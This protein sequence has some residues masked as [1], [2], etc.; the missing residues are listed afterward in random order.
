[1]A[2]SVC[3]PTADPSWGSAAGYEIDH[4]TWRDPSLRNPLSLVN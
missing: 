1:M 2:F 4:L 3:A